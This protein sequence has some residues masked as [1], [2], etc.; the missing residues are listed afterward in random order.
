MHLSATILAHP[1]AYP[2]EPGGP[3]VRPGGS[4]RSPAILAMALA[5]LLLLAPPLLGNGGIVRFSRATVGPYFVTV[6]S[7]PTP[8][9]TGELD[10]SVLVQD[11]A[12]QT[13]EVPIVVVASPVVLVE[14]ATAEPIRKPATRAQATN[15]L[16]EAAKFDVDA[17]GEWS[18]EIEIADVGQLTFQA[19]VARTTIL[20]RPWLMATLIVLPL[21]VLGWFFLGR[22]EEE[23]ATLSPES[24]R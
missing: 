5:A 23:E 24:R 2:A 6:Y 18:F 11:S 1:P 7:A 17:P 13:V 16:F 4:H 9:R 14:G 12:N 3:D 10:I 22:E 8:L 21:A 20:D 19:P 15:K